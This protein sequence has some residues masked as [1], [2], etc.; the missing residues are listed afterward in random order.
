[1]D[2]RMSVSANFNNSSVDD[3]SD[4]ENSNNNNYYREKD[5]ERH[6]S[7]SVLS[8]TSSSSLSLIS[9]SA[10]SMLALLSGVEGSSTDQT[11]NTIITT[12]AATSTESTSIVATT[13]ASHAD[14]ESPTAGAILAVIVMAIVILFFGITCKTLIMQAA[15]RV[16]ILNVA[17]E[18]QRR[19]GVHIVGD[20]GGGVFGNGN[21]MMGARDPDDNP[22][23]II[24]LNEVHWGWGHLPGEIIPMVM[25][26][27][28]RGGEEEEAEDAV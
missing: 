22:D 2:H 18:R 6:Q 11:S 5:G 17:P 7:S 4:T 12:D 24:E 8:R 15:R 21:A 3:C 10:I 28:V 20:I 25:M 23:E 13:T 27:G 9:L 19:G 1:M 26:G 14:N 16:G